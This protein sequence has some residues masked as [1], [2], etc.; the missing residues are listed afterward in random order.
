[1]ICEIGTL[2]PTINSMYKAFT[3][4]ERK[5]ADL[6]ISEPKS[7]MYNVITEIASKAGVG[8]TTVVRFCRKLGF[9][10]YYD[11]R[12]SMTQEVSQLPVLTNEISTELNDK[13]SISD[14]MQKMALVNANAIEDT[15]NMLSEEDIK[16]VVE[17][18]SQ[19]N[20]IYFY[21]LGFSGTIA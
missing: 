16:K 2:L 20:R 14:V 21:G 12:I 15:I 3:K 19:S 9:N 4:S 17:F 5:V 13:D 7:V 11:F 1:M 6:I 10:G 18:I 8:D